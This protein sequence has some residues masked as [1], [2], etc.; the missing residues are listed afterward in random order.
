MTGPADPP[1]LRRTPEYL[2][3]LAG[4]L[5]L[6]M[7][8]G[9]GAFAFPLVTFA[10]TDSLGATGMVALVQGL[11]AVIGIV[12]GGLLSDRV[13][14]RRLRLLAGATGALLQA[15]LVAV[16]LAGGAGAAVL[17][18]IAFLDRLRGSLLGNASNAMLKQLVPRRCCRGRCR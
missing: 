13:E 2:K 14:R 11:G 16:L 10:V 18:V 7:G 17:A 6:D 5:L 15:V 1:P 4:D 9:I 3:W 8:T 12:P